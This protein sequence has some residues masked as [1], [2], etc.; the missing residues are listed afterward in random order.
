VDRGFELCD[1]AE[2]GRRADLRPFKD[3][4]LQAPAGDRSLKSWLRPWRSPHL[5][6]P[7]AQALATAADLGESIEG[8]LE[9]FVDTVGG[10][11]LIYEK[12]GADCRDVVV[13]VAVASAARLVKHNHCLALRQLEVAGAGYG[14]VVNRYRPHETRKSI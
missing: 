10:A 13:E 9:K 11:S 1:A 5:W 8:L 3:C 6:L 14:D 2:R 7:A 12:C 4:V